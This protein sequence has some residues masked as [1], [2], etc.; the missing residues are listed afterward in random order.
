MQ[1]FLK[2]DAKYPAQL[3]LILLT[4]KIILSKCT[5]GKVET[6]NMLTEIQF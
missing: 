2:C 4:V 1:N 6:K 5:D 3:A